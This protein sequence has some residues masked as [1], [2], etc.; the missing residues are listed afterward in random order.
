MIGHLETVV[1]TKFIRIDDDG[2]VLESIPATIRLTAL[3]AEQFEQARL[4]ML[5]TKSKIEEA[6]K[7]SQNT[8]SVVSEPTTV[9]AAETLEQPECSAE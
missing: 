3:S 2:N 8:N 9:S 6:E 1:Q 7:T 4:H 5:Q